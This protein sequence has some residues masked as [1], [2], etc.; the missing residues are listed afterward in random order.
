MRWV[1]DPSP[2]ER[3][4][5]RATGSGRPRVALATSRDWPALSPDDRPILAA[6]ERLDIDPRIAIWTDAQIDWSSF[7]LIVVRSCWDYHD[8][9]P[10]WLAWVADADRGG[11]LC[12][13]G[14]VLAWNAQKTY[15]AELE[16]AGVPV[17]PTRF[18]A[19]PALASL[20]SLERAL[21]SCPW[22]D[23]VCKPAVSAGALGTFRIRKNELG[24]AGLELAA[25]LPELARR[26]PLLVQPFL[27]EIQ[28][29]GEQS[30][31]FFEGRFSHAV[32]KNP[33]AGD[34]RVQE[35]HGGRTTS[36]EAT[37]SMKA[38]G[39]RAL[40]AACRLTGLPD[41][42]RLLYA[43]LDLVSVGEEHLLME[44]E[45]TEPALFLD[46]MP[47]AKASILPVDRLAEVIAHRL[48]AP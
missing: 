31:L 45:L 21:S 43:R 15:L 3:K 44:L 7:D 39:E 36:R 1:G 32:I 24:R 4:T 38:T 25:A 41:P 34:F 46:S 11:R 42:S 35:K 48:A 18:I 13:P 12:N 37:P 47:D 28:T 16:A 30:L 9:L 40:A 17:V 14:S 22:D 20:D 2:E 5:Q 8:D 19:L 27:P 26:G 23:F 29:Q 33:A 10:R 6:L